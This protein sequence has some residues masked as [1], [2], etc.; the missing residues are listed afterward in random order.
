MSQN[1]DPPAA[2]AGDAFG[3]DDGGGDVAVVVGG[4]CVNYSIR[5]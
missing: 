4:D 2:E 5:S 1:L 3:A